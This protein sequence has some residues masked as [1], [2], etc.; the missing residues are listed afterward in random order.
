MV[1]GNPA[2]PHAINSVGL[3]RR[4]FTEEQVRNIREAY[5]T[6]YRLDL[7]LSEALEKLQP[8]AVSQPEI[9]MFVD[10]IGDSTRSIVR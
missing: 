8:L 7:K 4:G 5:R 10:F 9:R 6:V 2:Q 3:K 1:A